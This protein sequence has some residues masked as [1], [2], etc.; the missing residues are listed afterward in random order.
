MGG[1]LIKQLEDI[2][3]GIVRAF[4]L[5]CLEITVQ[6]PVLENVE[7]LL[8]VCSS[9]VERGSLPIENRLCYFITELEM[10]LLSSLVKLWLFERR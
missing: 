6:S 4:K 2:Y 7:S 3:D 1:F 9:L 8:S 5:G 10:Y